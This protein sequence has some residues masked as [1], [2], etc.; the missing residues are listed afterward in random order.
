MLREEEERVKRELTA[1][2]SEQHDLNKILG[3]AG[4]GTNTPDLLDED[5]SR[6]RSELIN[7]RSASDSAAARLTSLDANRT[8]STVALDAEADQ[9][10]A[11]DT[12]LGSM[13]ATLFQ[14]RAT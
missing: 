1:D 8:H 5:L 9:M 12:G 6:V 14:R 4:V 10:L 7:A 13:R 2:R 3:V 11:V